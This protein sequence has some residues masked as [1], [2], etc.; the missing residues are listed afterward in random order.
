[1]ID[2]Q[3]LNLSNL[4]ET[5]NCQSLPI[6]YFYFFFNNTLKSLLIVKHKKILMLKIVQKDQHPKPE[7]QSF[8]VA[9]I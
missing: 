9:V 6:N 2:P 1:L 5:Q 4:R 3:R 8:Y 7:N